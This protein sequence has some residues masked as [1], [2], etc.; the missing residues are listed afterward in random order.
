M[1]KV[2][3][4]TFL[5]CAVAIGLPLASAQ[6]APSGAQ[7]APAADPCASPQMAAPEYAVYNNAMTQTDTKA[8]AA[9][10]EQYLT[11]FPQSAVQE[12]TLER[13]VALYNS[14]NDLTKE[15]DAADRLL[16]VNPTNITALLAEAAIRKGQADSITDATAKQAA[17]DSA[18]SY[19]QKGLAAP[20]P[21][22]TPDATFT[23]Q[24]NT[25]YPTFYSVI[26]YA[27]V[28]KKDSPTAID[29]YKKELALVPP[30]ATKTPGA[31]LQDVYYLG[32]AYMQATPPDY[33]SCAFYA[34][35]AVAYAPDNFKA[36]LSPT[37]KYC[38][39]KYHGGDDGYDAVVAA[40]TANL[41]PP[42]GFAAT[43]K[44][45]PTPADIVNQVI[46]TT[47]DL[48]TLA[49]GDKEFI[50]QS[51]TPDQAAK[52][53]DTVKGKSFQIDGVVVAATP[54]QIQLAVS[55]DAKQSKT[56]DFTVNLAPDDT[57][58]KKLTPLQEKA[59]TAKAAA[60][61]AATAVGATAT[62]SGTY[63]SFTPSPIMITMK[64]GEVILP[65]AATKPAPKPVA[66]PAARKPVAH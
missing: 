7:P 25:F 12:S 51:G 35:R 50:L 64:D 52:V 6:G 60:I 17:L 23:T 5:A 9:G 11:Q 45:A 58:D 56:A 42:D 43:V 63:D 55:D 4:A 40:A 18:A 14:F 10:L 3:L 49:V 41:N 57:A 30:D 15:L 32:V 36:Q 1:K 37:A 24:K 16:K 39:K 54:T 65:K 26:G 46:Q 53:W 61:A 21:A 22:C 34:S 27:A 47:P 2:V 8:Q 66:H 44:P 31:V 38:Y 59:A 48:A 28:I 62:V 20:K 13:L 29:A 33:L 19:A